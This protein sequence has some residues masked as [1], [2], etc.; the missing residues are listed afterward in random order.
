MQGCID[1]P[2]D[3]GFINIVEKTRRYRIS[4]A[5]TPTT[6]VFGQMRQTFIKK[7]FFMNLVTHNAV[8]VTGAA[9]YRKIVE[10]IEFVRQGSMKDRITT[11]AIGKSRVNDLCFIARSA[12]VKAIGQQVNRLKKT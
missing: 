7:K 9:L 12:G 8:D 1:R 3:R 6:Q 10:M 4:I 5:T 2:R 11:I